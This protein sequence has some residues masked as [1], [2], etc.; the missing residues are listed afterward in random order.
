[1]LVRVAGI[2]VS[3]WQGDIDWKKVKE[4]GIGF[5]MI[6]AAA[7]TRE[8]VRFRENARGAAEAGIPMGTYLY[9][10]AV[11]EEQAA[12]EADFLLKLTA[13]YRFTYPLAYD[14]EDSVQQKLTNRQRTGL[15]ES[16]CS[17]IEAAG[18]YAL[19]Y[20]SKYWLENLFE[21]EKIARYDK[22]VAQW[23][24]QNTYQGEYGMWQHSNTGRV[25]GI[26]GAVDLDCAYK[27]YPVLTAALRKPGWWKMGGK[28]YYGDVKNQW[29]K[30][31]GRWYWFEP[32]GVM[33]TG[34]RQINGKW[35]YL[36]EETV[37]PLKEGQCVYTDGNG[38]ILE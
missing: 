9:S 31:D 27:D 25:G 2:D 29:R 16:F 5:V 19:L 15:V 30:I 36:S 32:S 1:M 8:D 35:Y 24:S 14:I 38:A 7:G 12:A 11:T 3:R 18:C 10:L 37:G 21:A 13:E 26:N 20:S 28:W 33:A 6:R 34:C 22:W 17:R 4:A 23:G